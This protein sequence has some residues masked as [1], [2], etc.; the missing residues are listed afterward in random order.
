MLLRQVPSEFPVSAV[1]HHSNQSSVCL[2][3]YCSTIDQLPVVPWVYSTWNVAVVLYRTESHIV[4]LTLLMRRN[5][6]LNLC[7]VVLAYAVQ[8]VNYRWMYHELQIMCI[9]FKITLSFDTD[10]TQVILTSRPLTTSQI[11]QIGNVQV[12]VI[13]VSCMDPRTWTMIDAEVIQLWIAT[14]QITFL[15]VNHQFLNKLIVLGNV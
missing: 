15:L 12:L 8:F 6:M 5:E 2:P 13:D 10:D 11:H 3:L 1:N 7:A 9:G 4:Q 14:E